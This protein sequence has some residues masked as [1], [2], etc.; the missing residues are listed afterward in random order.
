MLGADSYACSVLP[1]PGIDLRIAIEVIHENLPLS[2]RDN[3]RLVQL[4]VEIA[5]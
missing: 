1:I 3:L 2:E 4:V 5:S